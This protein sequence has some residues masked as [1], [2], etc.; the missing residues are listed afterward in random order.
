MTSTLLFKKNIILIGMPGC[1]KSTIG[2]ILASKL[3]I[4]F[5]DT[6]NYIENK[7]GKSISQIFRSGEAQFRSIETS[8]IKEVSSRIP[9]VISTGGGI[10]KNYENIELLKANGIIVFVNRSIENII[11]N[12][13]A[14]K[15]PLLKDNINNLYKLYQDRIKLYKDYCD[16]EVLNNGKLEDTVNE[17]MEVARYESTSY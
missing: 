11:K 14:E 9:S 4:L 17:I 5:I 12:I 3:N 13:D 8:I 2:S 16:Y 6:D 1:G 15:R 10:I 7:T